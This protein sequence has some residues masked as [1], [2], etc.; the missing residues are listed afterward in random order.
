MGSPPTQQCRKCLEKERFVLSAL[1]RCVASMAAL[2]GDFP[3]QSALRRADIVCLGPLESPIPGIWSQHRLLICN[4]C[5]CSVV[6]SEPKYTWYNFFWIKT[7]G[8]S[9]K[10]KFYQMHCPAITT[11]GNSENLGPGFGKYLV[12]IKV[13]LILWSNFSMRQVKQAF[14]GSSIHWEYSEHFYE[15]S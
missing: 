7:C 15:G 12:M 13:A 4:N 5:H 1:H 14:S 10:V 8:V 9:E 6:M 3:H 2:P 11:L